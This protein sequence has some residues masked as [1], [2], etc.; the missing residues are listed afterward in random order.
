M[1]QIYLI[2]LFLL[3]LMVL[4]CSPSEPEP[5]G[6][7][8]AE[9]PSLYMGAPVTLVEFPNGAIG[10]KK[11]LD[12]ADK[13]AW[14]KPTIEQPVD[15]VW[16]LGGYGLAPMSIIDTHEGLI[17]F[18]TGDT[19]HDG[20]L[21]LEAIRSFTDKPVKAII[22]GHSHTVFGAGVLA[23]GNENVM[24]IGHPDLNAVVEKNLQGGGAPAYFPE[25]GP[26]LTA[27][28]LIQFNNYMPSEGPDAWV[29][30]LLLPLGEM[31]FLP[32]NTP[33]QD[34]QEMTVLGVKMQFFTKYGSDDKVHTTVWLPDRK[35]VFTTLL[36]SSPPQLYSVRG[37]VF[38]DPRV[39]IAGLKFTRDL[40]AEVLISAAAR[41]VVGKDNIRETLQGYLDGASFVLDQTL[42]GILGGK[43]PDELR[44]LVRFPKYLDEVPN[45]LQNYGEIS[46]YSPA[47]YYQSVGWYDNDAANL[48]RVEPGDEANRM[49]ALIGGRAKVLAA[50]N[51]ALE[52]HEFAWA[53]QLVNYLYRI[54][55]QD[56][57]VRTVKAEALRQMAYVSTGGN[58]RAHLMSQALA[59]E[60]KVTIPRLIP[61]PPEQI[62]A[63][64]ATFVDYFRV[65]IDPLK[66]DETDSF[67]RFDFADGTSAGL[68]IRR[69]IAEFVA[70]PD[71]YNRK[72]DVIVSMSGET[73]ARLYL[74]QATPEELIE[75]GD[76]EI[77]SDAGEAA[78]LINL[79]DRYSP[80][81]AVVVPS[82]AL[83]HM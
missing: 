47:I 61:P 40:E 34:G 9:E 83:D 50:A 44:H 5:E 4:G 66:S 15:G 16:V 8:R 32:V 52:K 41:P 51:D 29:A 58:D 63:S 78:R 75:S 27:R 64:P 73:W 14:L 2:L 76:L 38:R 20:E 13:V 23:E 79:F 36:W 1:K 77:T 24:V 74:S 43:G 82:A 69:A 54:D 53:A 19:K 31:A 65:R 18:D 60:G 59:L 45:N 80:E 55:P 30:P 56:K 6:V 57:E 48:K 21:F 17:V 35:I 26:Y 37:D 62:S 49:V 81:K 25:I 7:A 28:A 42:R 68:H 22:Y 3:T 12:G 71:A 39:W 70:L 10:N 11:L 67:I 46:S 72:P 33:V